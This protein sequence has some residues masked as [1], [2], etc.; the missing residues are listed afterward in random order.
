MRS[1]QLSDTGFRGSVVLVTSTSGYFGLTGNVAYAA[2]KHGIVGLLRASQRYAESIQ[3]RVNA[4]APSYTPTYITA[5][6]G[7]KFR[8]A[9]VESNTPETVA[10]AIAYAAVD[11]AR[12]GTC[13]L[14]SQ[15]SLGANP[16]C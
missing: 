2:S 1:N 3:I 8:E 14:V 16:S 12:H 15:S 4:I 10:E 9:G 7:D 11:A 5:G 6:F 13:H